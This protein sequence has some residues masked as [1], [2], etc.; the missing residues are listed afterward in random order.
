M[1]RCGFCGHEYTEEEGIKG[2]G[3]CGKPCRSIRCPKCLYENPVEPAV[4]KKLKKV[5][6]RKS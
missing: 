4:V 1:I 2:C 5:F 3:K 6:T